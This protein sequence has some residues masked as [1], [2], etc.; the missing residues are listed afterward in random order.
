MIGLP[1][2]R[3]YWKSKVLTQQNNI[4][5]RFTISSCNNEIL[6]YWEP[7]APPFEERLSC[8]KMAFEKG[9]VTSVSMEPLLE[10]PSKTI[11]LVTPYVNDCIWTGFLNYLKKE[12]PTIEECYRKTISEIKEHSPELVTKFRPNP[13]IYFKE[14]VMEYLV[15]NM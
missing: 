12:D 5:F 14:S 2:I 13:M 7:N 9:Y 6:K 8:L 10:D 11:E 15:K 4:Q 3:E 1:S